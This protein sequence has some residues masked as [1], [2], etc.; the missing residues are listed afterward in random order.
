MSHITK[1]RTQLKDGEVLRRALKKMCYR[2]DEK[3]FISHFRDVGRLESL[4]LVARKGRHRIGFRRSDLGDGSYEILA[5]WGSLK[6]RREEIINPI[7]QMY[8]QEKILD[9]ARR[10][11]YAVIKNKANRNGQIEI[12][13]RKVA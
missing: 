9:L 6:D 3:D 11:G 2:V 5:D 13:I 12:I 7:L 8:S 4:E 10:K 1:V